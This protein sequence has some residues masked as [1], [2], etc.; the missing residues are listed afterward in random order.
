MQLAHS[1]T[2]NPFALGTFPINVTMKW[3]YYVYINICGLDAHMQC[4]PKNKWE[5]PKTC[6]G[7][8]LKFD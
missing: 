3:C 6:F 8:R 7:R 4:K 2:I 1:C 5:S